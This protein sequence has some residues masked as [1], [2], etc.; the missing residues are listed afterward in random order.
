MTNAEK[1][2]I[3]AA[4][5]AALEDALKENLSEESFPELNLLVAVCRPDLL[6][7]EKEDLLN[8]LIGKKYIPQDNSYIREIVNGRKMN[9]HCSLIGVPCQIISRPYITEVQTFTKD[10]RER[11][12]IKVKSLKTGLIYEVMFNEGWICN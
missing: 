10:K 3:A 2:I 7:K 11:R 6:L 5:D 4:I 1:I 8:S 9:Y 12:M